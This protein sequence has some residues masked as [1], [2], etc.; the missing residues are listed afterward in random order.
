[1][2]M[3]AIDLTIE[4]AARLIHL[5]EVGAKQISDLCYQRI[6]DLNDEFNA[7]ITVIRNA[8]ELN[9]REGL[10]QGVPI[11]V[12]DLF[13]TKGVATTAGTTFFREFVPDQNALVVQKLINAGAII[14]GKTNTHEIALG[15]TGINPHYGTVMNPWD[16][17]RI[18]GGSSSGSAVAVATG[19]AL[20]ALGTDTGGSIRIPAS[21][22]G[23]VGL[24]PTYGRVSTR[25]VVPLS[26]NLDAPGPLTKTVRDAAILL[27]VIAG[28]DELDPN[29]T[30][31]PV[32]DYLSEI[33]Q[34]IADLK[35]G[36]LDGDYSWDAEPDVL[37]IIREAGNCFISL[38][39]TVTPVELNFL[40]EAAFSNTNMLLTDAAAFHKTR[41]A[42]NPGGFGDDTRTRLEMGR[43]QSAIDYALARKTQLDSK[44]QMERFFHHYDVLILPSTPVP[45]PFLDGT[46][47]IKQ[48]RSLTRFTAPFNLTGLPAISIP[49]GFN[50]EGL[51]VGLQIVTQAWAE[52][53]L[54]RVA[55]AFEQATE[56]HKSK[57]TC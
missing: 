57:P 12:K 56:W 39:A 26:W 1:M 37:E 21:L 14:N 55:H 36:I 45:A 54:L 6:T 46:D 4:Q 53:K 2:S 27:Q 52:K 5:G 34:G 33:G 17:K 35:I 19:M 44:R 32:D 11:A 41:L 51:P 22:C 47:A 8:D 10:L 9:D 23:V 18:S 24:K 29:S 30:Q 25:G 43:D 20:G 38:G 50:S 15:V 3:N 31:H 40:R 48:S 49:A 13:Q 16:K 7:Y 28:Y 42:E